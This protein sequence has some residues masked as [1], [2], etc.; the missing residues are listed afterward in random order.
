IFLLTAVRAEINLSISQKLMNNLLKDYKIEEI[1]DEIKSRGDELPSEEELQKLG[2][3]RAQS[4]IKDMQDQN[5]LVTNKG[6]YQIEANYGVGQVT[7]N[8]QPLDLGS[9]L[10]L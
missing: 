8:G 3:A 7:L 4:E 2:V 10:G 6:K 1:T 9:L 5:I